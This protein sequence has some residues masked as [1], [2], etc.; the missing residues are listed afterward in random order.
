[1]AVQLP[2]FDLDPMER[3]KLWDDGVHLKPAGYDRFAEIV[4]DSIKKYL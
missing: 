2:F 3:E 4:F 1:L